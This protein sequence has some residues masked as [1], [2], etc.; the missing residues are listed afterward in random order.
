MPSE[1]PSTKPAKPSKPE[2]PFE[3]PSTFPGQ[4]IK[5][6]AKP[7]PFPTFPTDPGDRPETKPFPGK[8]E[9]PVTLP[10]TLPER[11]D[12]PGK[13]EKPTTLPG[14]FPGKPGKPETLPGTLPERPDRPG[15]PE[16]PTTL[17][18]TVPGKPEK[19]ETL[20]GV[21]PE[22]PG[23]PGKPGRPT[24]PE[25]QRP[26][27]PPQPGGGIGNGGNFNNNNINSGNTTVIQNRPVWNPVTVNQLTSVNNYYSTKNVSYNQWVV[28]RD[29]H[30]RRWSDERWDRLSDH[31]DHAEEHWD[32]I[33]RWRRDRYDDVIYR[34]G[35]W[36]SYQQRVWRY[37]MDRYND[38]SWRVKD[39]CADL[40]TPDWWVHVGFYPRGT[41]VSVNPWWWWRRPAWN[42]VVNHVQ[43]VDREPIYYDYGLNV[44]YQGKVVY[45]DGRAGSGETFRKGAVALASVDGTL[46][47]P[48]P[49]E[50]GDEAA[51]E[52]LPLGVW[53]LAQEEKGD[54]V[55]FLQLS[56]HT[57]GY[58]SGAYTV[59]A[60]GENHSLSGTVDTSSQR[61]AWRLGSKETIVEAGLANLSQDVAPC[62]VYF[63][64]GGEPQQ[65]VLM[66]MKSPDS[67]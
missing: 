33:Q 30:W 1:K 59:A 48:T 13:P 49:P 34:R 51:G 54:P 17:P 43:I 23:K 39:R 60:T 47:P 57:S 32:D 64:E 42:T 35:D 19:P 3:K 65:W 40:F 53:G 67:D 14:T 21:L 41:R 28:K 55:M 37:R 7:K 15:K 61:A 26:N 24:P 46:P 6:G 25:W 56:L 45:L 8:P 63:A 18:G 31:W 5:P 38:W 58:I 9:K 10:G 2:N 4:T 62:F 66:R 52:W 16:K 44:I 11:P 36:G 12:K 22:R 27:P 20:P 50:G 29:D